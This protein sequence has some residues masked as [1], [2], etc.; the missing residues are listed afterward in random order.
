M[1]GLS[2]KHVNGIEKIA[3]RLLIHNQQ[4]FIFRTIIP[5]KKTITK[6]SSENSL[7]LKISRDAILKG[8]Q[9]GE[10][11]IKEGRIFTHEEAKE[12]LKKWLKP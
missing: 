1:Q 12:K 5:M 6:S 3:L 4:H 2:T 10:Q 9:K 7:E 11:A 8:I